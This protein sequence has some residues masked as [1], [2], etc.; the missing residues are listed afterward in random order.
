VHVDARA[1]HV[2]RLASRFLAEGRWD[3]HVAL[4]REPEGRA[5]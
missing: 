4:V 1:D 3:N 2:T 5:R